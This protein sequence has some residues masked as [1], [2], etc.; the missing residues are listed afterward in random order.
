[1]NNKG[2]KEANHA[3]A[4]LAT[5]VQREQY[6]KGLKKAL[7]MAK[8]QGLDRLSPDQKAAF[9]KATMVKV[10]RKI[11][12]YPSE[13]FDFEKV[14]AREAG[15]PL[16]TVV[17]ANHGAGGSGGHLP[18]GV[19]RQANGNNNNNNH[20]HKQ[21]NVPLH[22][23]EEDEEKQNALENG[24]DEDTYAAY[25]AHA[26]REMHPEVKGHP[27]PLVETASLRSV[28][29]PK[30]KFKH[31]LE[32]DIKLGRLSD[33]QVE[34]VIYA[35]MRFLLNERP[36]PGFFL[37][38]GAG[39]GK[40][41]QIAALIK[42]H[43]LEGGRCV[44]WVSVSPDLKLDAR[45]DLDDMGADHIPIYG[46]GDIPAYGYQGVCFI[47]YALLRVG[48]PKEEKKRPSSDP[49]EELE[50]SPVPEVLPLV[51]IP[52]GSR[53]FQILDWLRGCPQDCL[54]IFD[55][56]HKAKN[57]LPTKGSAPTQ[58]GKAVLALQHELPN[59]KVVYSSATGASEPR[60][61]AYM[62]RLGMAGVGD[63][64]SVIE[65]LQ[66]SQLGALELAAM[67]LKASGAYLARSLSYEGAEFRMTKVKIDPAFRL[68]YDRSVMVWD[69]LY[70]IMGAVGGKR[71]T[72][73]Y[74]GAHQ[75][76]YRSMLMAGKVSTIS[77]MAR[78]A[79]K[80]GMA[81]VIGLQSTGEAGTEQQR[82]DGGEF[83]D[84][85]RFVF[86]MRGRKKVAFN[87]LKINV[88]HSPETCRFQR[89]G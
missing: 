70:R 43:W 58:T 13:G 61:L 12:I 23:Q 1:M 89:H 26:I 45:R 63:T 35:N 28:P 80:N 36:R 41:R 50:E 19:A 56:S 15:V 25:K 85:V 60:N 59:A 32:D 39:V 7:A 27:D 6:R 34:T 38:D 55:E 57:L 8:E 14:H 30:P 71:W 48:L 79:V 3:P 78:K 75:R 44:L 10:K 84:L 66:Q 16:D 46:K 64:T 62:V 5:P 18:G 24:E 52:E 49:L 82:L 54:V 88:F 20:N 74:W 4:R 68:M 42:Q 40:G 76:F 33:A 47:T 77:K 72:T 29:L 87:L 51:N 83:D 67:S 86:V 53:L 69:L 2:K 81:V 9:V 17:W 22:Q 31:G 11:G 37:G 65:V 21:S 73:Q